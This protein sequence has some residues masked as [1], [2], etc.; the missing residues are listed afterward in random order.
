MGITIQKSI[1]L[2]QLLF[3][4]LTTELS[5]QIEI[6]TQVLLNESYVLLF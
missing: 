5:F 3:G 6:R 2:Q 1:S 4:N